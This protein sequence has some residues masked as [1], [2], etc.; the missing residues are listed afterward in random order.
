MQNEMVFR[1]LMEKYRKDCNND[2][3]IPSKEYIRLTRIRKNTI[4]EV[5]PNTRLS[6]I[7]QTGPC[8]WDTVQD[9]R[10]LCHRSHN[11]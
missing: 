1:N 5:C 2:E 7:S 4:Q 3:I 9:S 6:E 10:L 8:F 11:R